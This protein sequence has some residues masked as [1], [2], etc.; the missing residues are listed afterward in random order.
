MTTSNPQA[1]LSSSSGTLRLN[2]WWKRCGGVAQAGVAA[3]MPPPSA[4]SATRLTSRPMR[5]R[6]TTSP[7]GPVTQHRNSRV[8]RSDAERMQTVWR[9]SARQRPAWAVW[10]ICPGEPGYARAVHRKGEN[11]DA[12]AWRSEALIDSRRPGRTRPGVDSELIRRTDES[13]VC[14]AEAAADRLAAKLQ[15]GKGTVEAHPLAFV[16]DDPAADVDVVA[17]VHARVAAGFHDAGR[18]PAAA[19]A[20]HR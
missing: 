16:A 18:V 1:A 10:A 17:A 12:Q 8:C 11:R 7:L 20:V 3:S 4:S 14:A 6:M 19:A 9:S 13:K 2:C 5:R 15:P